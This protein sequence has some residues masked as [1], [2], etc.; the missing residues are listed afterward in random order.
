MQRSGGIWKK[1][2]CQNFNVGVEVGVRRKNLPS[3]AHR[4]GTEQKIGFAA[5]NAA[6]TAT[7]RA[8]RGLLIISGHDRFIGKSPKLFPDLFELKPLTDS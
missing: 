7:I 8:L 3:A 4:D 5:G 6:R 1:L 2:Y